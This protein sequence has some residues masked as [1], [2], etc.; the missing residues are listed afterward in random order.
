MK[1]GNYNLTAA[2]E[3]ET[4]HRLF[5]SRLKK[6][7]NTSSYI[8]GKFN[9]QIN[10]IRKI[11]DNIGKR[12]ASQSTGSPPL[13][14]RASLFDD[15][16]HDSEKCRELRE[17][18]EK[19]RTDDSVYES[20]S[21]QK[22]FPDDF[23]RPGSS[24]FDDRNS[25]NEHCVF[26]NVKFSKINNA[27]SGKRQHKMQKNVYFTISTNKCTNTSNLYETVEYGSWNIESSRASCNHS[28]RRENDEPKIKM[29]LS[30]LLK[31]S[32][33][34]EKAELEILKNYFEQMTYSEIC[35]DSDFKNYLKKKNYQDAIDYI[36]SGTSHMG[37]SLRGDKSSIYGAATDVLRRYYDL[38]L[39]IVKDT[40][41]CDSI[42]NEKQCVVTRP[43]SIDTRKYYNKE[44]SQFF[45]KSNREFD[46]YYKQNTNIFYEATKTVADDFFEND[47][48]DLYQTY[49][50][51][52]RLFQEE[53]RNDDESLIDELYGHKSQPFVYCTMPTRKLSRDSI[54]QSDPNVNDKDDTSGF[55]KFQTFP[56]KRPRKSYEELLRFCEKSLAHY[57]TLDIKMENWQKL[58][59]KEYSEKSYGKI[60]KAFVR[61]R[62]FE[63]VE[64]YV[65]YHYGRILDKSF[66]SHL[67]ARLKET[68]SS[69][70]EQLVISKPILRT[71]TQLS[72]AVN[73]RLESMPPPY[74]S[75]SYDNDSNNYFYKRH[76]AT[77]TKTHDDCFKH[78]DNIKVDYARPKSSSVDGNE[79]CKRTLF[80]FV[81]DMYENGI[82]FD[83]L[84]V[85]GHHSRSCEN[86]KSETHTKK[87]IY[88]NYSQC[89][90]IDR[91]LNEMGKRSVDNIYESIRGEAIH[92][93]HSH[94]CIEAKRQ[95]RETKQT[96]IA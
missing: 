44:N 14:Y 5:Y 2:T 46:D 65:Q 71:T 3:T 72:V 43:Q 47:L 70:N 85:G 73:N 6:V 20:C 15:R 80:K 53:S 96:V 49:E 92:K 13:S 77:Q 7:K 9:S 42:K 93:H 57:A 69:Q 84:I 75:G 52:N 36:Y 33:Y 89:N 34:D 59:K 27:I 50:R 12:K 94:K 48:Q 22:Y 25:S 45:C 87:Q 29:D 60:I 64:S 74:T 88:N 78:F 86:L 11:N 66:D 8:A 19:Y 51:A 32:Q 24:L 68:M 90:K 37:S 21:S 63:N 31:P 76:Q 54:E 55:T 1:F 81:E 82:D 39:D 67:K 79:P 61:M 18:L 38:D 23:H 95:A 4:H 40:N 62:G 17:K 83:G 58:S 16:K 30:T 28:I 35:K 56:K 26:D 91:K 10:T 41:D